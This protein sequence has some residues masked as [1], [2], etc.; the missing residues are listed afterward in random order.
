[1]QALEGTPDDIYM[2]QASRLDHSSEIQAKHGTEQE[3]CVA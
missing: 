3:Q 2:L 1:M